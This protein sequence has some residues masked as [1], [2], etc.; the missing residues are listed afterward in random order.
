MRFEIMTWAG[1]DARPESIFGVID[2]RGS[3]KLPAL[4]PHG[5]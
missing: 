2:G 1:D 3:G 4:S 5:H